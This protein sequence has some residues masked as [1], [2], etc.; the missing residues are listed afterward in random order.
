MGRTAEESVFGSWQG[1]KVFLLSTASRPALR[2]TQPP[3]KWVPGTKR[4]LREPNHSSP[5]SAKVKNFGAI[6]PLLHTYSRRD[7]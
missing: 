7:A 4:P 2:P 3:I 6:P 5:A 1:Y